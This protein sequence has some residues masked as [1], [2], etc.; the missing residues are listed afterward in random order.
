MRIPIIRRAVARSKWL[1]GQRAEPLNDPVKRV[2][3]GAHPHVQE[4]L[5]HTVPSIF[6]G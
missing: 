1:S 4:E 3:Q 6:L 2:D 5:Q